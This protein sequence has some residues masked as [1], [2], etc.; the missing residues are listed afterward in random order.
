MPKSLNDRASDAWEFC[1]AIADLAGGE[2][3]ERAR[4]AALEVSGD[5]AVENESTRIKLLSD[6]REIFD[7]T[8][9][10][11][12]FSEEIVKKLFELNNRPWTEWGKDRKPITPTAMSRLLSDLL[13]PG[14][15][16]GSVWKTG[17][18]AKG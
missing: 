11:T 5:G 1:I 3:P 13:P 15:K 16:P 4:A 6:I 17:K 12:L 9:A 10:E 8:G 14:V 7:D 18:S 2:W